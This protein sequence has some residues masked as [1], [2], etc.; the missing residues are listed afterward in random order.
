MTESGPE[1]DFGWNWTPQRSRG[2][3]QARRYPVR[4]LAARRFRTI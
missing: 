1:A 2:L 3:L 4:I